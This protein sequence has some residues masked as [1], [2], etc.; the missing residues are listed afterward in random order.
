[1]VTGKGYKRPEHMRRDRRRDRRGEKG[2]GGAVGL[3]GGGKSSAAVCNGVLP[4]H[5]DAMVFT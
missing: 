2:G 4:P 5:S 3:G 1:M